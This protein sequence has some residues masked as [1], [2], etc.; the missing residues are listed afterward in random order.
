MR[1]LWE[2]SRVGLS[3]W[4]SRML[5]AQMQLCKNNQH[6]VASSRLFGCCRVLLPALWA[7]KL[8]LVTGLSL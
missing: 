3:V 7:V 1:P 8:H 2:V 5:I 4:G 6:H